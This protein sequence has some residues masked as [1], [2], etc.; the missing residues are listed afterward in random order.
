[1]KR[2][3]MSVCILVV[4][5]G[6]AAAQS[7]TSTVTQSGNNDNANIQQTGSLNEGT[8][9]QTNG[10]YNNVLMTQASIN[11]A[12]Y[13]KA[14]TATVNQRGSSNTSKINQ[15]RTG[16]QQSYQS[17]ATVDQTGTNNTSV[18]Q[19][20]GYYQG[21][22]SAKATQIGNNNEVYQYQINDYGN[23]VESYQNGNYD[24]AKQYN[25]KVASGNH[26]YISQTGGNS[27]HAEQWGYGS[28][29][30]HMTALQTG[31]SNYSY[32]YQSGLKN[33]ESVKQTG[34]GNHAEQ[35]QYHGS[36]YYNGQYA[37]QHT[38][39]ITQIGN[40]NKAYQYQD[41]NISDVWANSRNTS[42]IY[43]KGSSD[44]SHVSQ[45]DGLNTGN[46]TQI[47]GNL[48]VGNIYQYSVGNM[49]TISQNG[50]G[51]YGQVTQH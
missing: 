31:T 38:A 50:S 13:G 4:A 10:N 42:S 22:N 46:V 51:N 1:M 39:D 44:V 29:N 32:Q 35:R 25:A 34:T 23:N 2:I 28:D 21:S 43:Q 36:Y 20:T 37:H 17:T 11:G 26:D 3:L 8:V 5:A 16:G 19:Q 18:I 9:K 48:N 7:N 24:Y 12:S 47:G 49:A 45:Y 40:D 27:Q 30:Q 6:L 14:T 41:E 15:D 33:I